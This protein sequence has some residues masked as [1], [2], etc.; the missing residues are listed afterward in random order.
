MKN[1]VVK[2]KGATLFLFRELWFWRS[3]Y[4][5]KCLKGSFFFCRSKIKSIK[6]T[7]HPRVSGDSE[8]LMALMHVLYIQWTCM[9]MTS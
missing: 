5:Y 8:T 6:P 4:M 1:G 3:M 9:Q 2:R 7:T